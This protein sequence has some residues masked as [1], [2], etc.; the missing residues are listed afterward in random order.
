MIQS[1]HILRKD[2]RH[3]WVDL[4]LY[5]AL[6]VAFSVVMPNIWGETNGLN[7][8]LAFFAGLLKILIPV[9]WLVLIARLI[10]DESLVG[11]QQFWITRP[12]TWGSLVGAKL[13]FIAL[14]VVLPFAL[15]QWTLLLQAGLNPLR[16]MGAQSLTMLY[17]ALWVW[18]PFV[19]VAAVTSSMQRMFMSM[20]AAVIFWGAVLTMLG[21]SS[22][23]RM[24]PPYTV[25]TFSVLAGV[26]LLGI[27]LYQ[28]ASRNTLRSRIALIGTTVLFVGLF[29]GFVEEEIPGP[30]NMLIRHHYAASTNPSLRLAFD[31]SLLP[32]KDVESLRIGKLVTMHLPVQ[33]QGLDDADQLDDKDVSF[34]VDAPGYHY[35]SPWRP[36]F[37][38]DRDGWIMLLIPQNILDRIHGSNV[39]MHLSMVVTRMVPGA[40]Q[41]VTAADHF[42]VP[43]DGG[44]ELR[45]NQSSSYAACRFPFRT[46]Q[47]TAVKGLVNTAPCGSSAPTHLSVKMIG[48]RSAGTVIDP[49]VPM[50]LS[51]GG[52]VCPGT[53]LSFVA[54]HPAE[55]FRLELDIPE[56]L[57]DQYVTK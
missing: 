25:E 1:L 39:R 38:T 29:W 35:A 50:P 40:S 15:M 53:Q 21:S 27:L 56:I 28:Y 43:G 31:P 47:E 51:L 41:V 2:I 54:Y 36:L 12:Y 3:L 34:T 57:L 46:P 37:N 33:I 49:I 17:F 16:A 23:P 6:L 19:A 9:L 18:L 26:L 7:P 14:C 32:S 20:L 48:R 55:N 45:T 42:D 22:G 5:V 10:H 4:T 44:C 8:A 24:T 11:D 52:N 30:A 13:L